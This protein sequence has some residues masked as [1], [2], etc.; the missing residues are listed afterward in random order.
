MPLA[1]AFAAAQSHRNSVS[2]ALTRVGR[3]RLRWSRLP[4][5]VNAPRPSPAAC[6]AMLLLAVVAR[7]QALP[8]PWVPPQNPQTPAKVV[9]GKILFW[10]EQLSSD[11]SVACGTCHL[12][13]LGGTDG[14]IADGVHPGADGLFGTADDVH[15][16]AG[17]VRQLANGDFA[18]A[19][20]FGV[21][22]QAT[23]RASATPLG[24]A[25]HVE[26]FWDG[27][28]GQA[29]TDPETSTLLIPFGAA[30]ENQALGPILNPVEMG[31][32]GRTWSDVRTKLSTAVPLRLARNL[33]PDLQAA[34]QQSPSYPA[35]FAA[36]F[37]SP[38]I[39]AAR[40]A[41]AIASYERTLVPD[42][43]PW[44]R[45]VAGESNA[46]NATEK[47]GWLVFQNQGR[48]IACHWAPLFADDLYHN[49]G[50][51]WAA[52]DIGRGAFSTAPDEH[53]AFKTPTLRNAGLRPRLFHNGQSVPL[54][55]PAQLTDPASV[56]NVYLQG[57]GID[58]TNLDPFLLPLAQLGVTAA[59]VQLALDFV[60]T[61]LTDPRA[62][63]RQPPF[64]HPDLRSIAVPPPRVFGASLAGAT[65]PVLIDSVP[66]FPGNAAYRLGLA[67]GHGATTALLTFGLQSFEPSLPVLG[68]PWHVQVLGHVPFALAGPAGQPG[69]ATWRL[70]LPNDPGLA[71][72]PLYF[73]LFA[74]DPQ[75][76]GG[77]AA[78][79]G[80]E[81]FVR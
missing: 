3:R 61:A 13:E 52:E 55:D 51:R 22:R 53:A 29:F 67:A 27:R 60:Q 40:I 15:G 1:A 59:E 8:P 32:E 33:T 45:Y 58:A 47:A 10:D 23:G 34:L 6:A 28:A 81:L 79:R 36:A 50:L 14:R 18:H 75:S 30:L 20:A 42:R 21:Q 66:S 48:C 11:D 62:R 64:D 37:G 73:Q 5:R 65:V 12:P 63:Y 69:L 38:S 43:T 46:M 26:L 71:T 39:T 25:Y 4:R 31:H 35:L 24:A 44:D 78:S 70:P 76:P 72:V 49:L 2:Q 77:I 16:S 56:L 7:A 19:G 74:L 54:G 41:M 68:M 80:W 17:V 57:G 9:L